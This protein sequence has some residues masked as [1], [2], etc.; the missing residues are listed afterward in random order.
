MSDPHDVIIRPVI[1]EKTYTASEANNT[2]TFVV[3]PDANKTQIRLAVEAIFGVTVTKVNTLNRQGKR[4]RSRRVNRW[5]KR[6]DT[7]RAM[8]TLAEGD[9]IEIYGS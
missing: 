3:A 1:S 7:K 6:P 5:S 2:Y 9:E 8:V 4:V